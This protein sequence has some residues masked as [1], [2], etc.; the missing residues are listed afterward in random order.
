M[1]ATRDKFDEL[2]LAEPRFDPVVSIKRHFFAAISPHPEELK[3]IEP[4]M[5]FSR[6]DP[7][8]IEAIDAISTLDQRPNLLELTPKEFES[9]VQ[10][11]FTQMGYETDQFR[12]SGDGASTAWRTSA[13]PLPR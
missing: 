6:A 1:R 7:R 12:T 5:P 13:I 11:L 3:E 4:V 8:V 2:V 10:N 9:F